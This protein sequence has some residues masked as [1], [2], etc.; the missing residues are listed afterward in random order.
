[1]KRNV[2]VALLVLAA[3]LVAG[4]AGPQVKGAGQDPVRA[5]LYAMKEEVVAIREYVIGENLA[6]R[7]DNTTVAEF[8][9]LDDKFTGVYR[10]TEKLYRSGGN[11]A[12]IDMNKKQLQDFLLEMRRTY[13]P[14]GG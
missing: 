1:M 4:C 13:Y 14:K 9:K 6:G 7:M 10:I 5:S 12:A 8:K 2:K 11:P 3:L